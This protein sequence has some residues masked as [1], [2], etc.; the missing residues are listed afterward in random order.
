MQIA[1]KDTA[2]SYALQ[3]QFSCGLNAEIGK[4][5]KNVILDHGIQRWDLIFANLAKQDPGR[6][7]QNI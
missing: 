7:R 1:C 3:V 5:T 2:F 6:A 4:I